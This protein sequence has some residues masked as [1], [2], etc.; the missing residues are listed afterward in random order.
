M[1]LNN[2][3]KSINLSDPVDSGWKRI[4]TTDANFTLIGFD[5]LQFVTSFSG[6][7]KYANSLESL[8]QFQFSGTKLRIL[9]YPHEDRSDDIRI[10][11]DGA[12]YTYSEKLPAGYSGDMYFA[13]VLEVSE[14]PNSN[15]TV[16]IYLGSAGIFTLDA[17]EI[18][19]SCALYPFNHI[20]P[21]VAVSGNSRTLY[22]V[23]SGMLFVDEFSTLDSRWQLTNSSYFSLTANPGKMTIKHHTARD[24]MLLMNR[25]E[26]K[27]AFEVVA[28]Y[29]PDIESDQGGIV[30]WQ[31]STEMVEFLESSQKGYD[32][33]Q[34][35]W[36]AVVDEYDTRLYSDEGEGF[37]MNDTTQFNGMTKIGVTLKSTAEPGA[38]DLIID[39][40][41]ATRG[42]QLT[43]EDVFIG[44]VVALYDNSGT[45]VASTEVYDGSK[46][47]L[48]LPSIMFEG[49]LSIQSTDGVELDSITGVFYGGDVY[50]VG[51]EIQVRLNG[52]ELN[53]NGLTNLGS[54]I[55]GNT[56]AL[57]EVYN[58]LGAEIKGVTIAIQQ[59][60]DKFGWTWSDIADG[61]SG[62]PGAFSDILVIDS[63]PAMSSYPFYIKVTKGNDA[64]FNGMESL[65]LSIHLSY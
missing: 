57:L 35:K 20:A 31:D 44:E 38:K 3:L 19:E 40:I 48:A 27:F 25:P 32:K 65:K 29:T 52:V 5:D 4:D 53:K 21:R 49:K 64:D 39:K 6:S 9:G 36:L 63:I 62:S 28:D 61:S 13:R 7:L 23:A 26:G 54:M 24:M 60:M 37:T 16:E 8:A 18:E 12:E 11:I 51:A 46:A 43:V 45:L 33:T 50:A 47:I 22:E 34:S 14:L 2:T 41:V 17:V 56:L 58:P 30:L 42:I 1:L 59:Y 55:G 15:H 10:V